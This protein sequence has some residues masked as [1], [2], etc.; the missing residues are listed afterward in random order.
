MSRRSNIFIGGGGGG[1]KVWSPDVEPTADATYV[2]AESYQ[3]GGANPFTQWNPNSVPDPYSTVPYGL[4]LT[5]P[6]SQN[7]SFGYIRALLATA[8][9]QAF[10]ITMPISCE[11][12]PSGLPS[13]VTA[14]VIL[15]RGLIANPATAPHL[16]IGQ[17]YRA[18]N[19][20]AWIANHL[21]INSFNVGLKDFVF[22]ATSPSPAG[23]AE[24]LYAGPANI[25]RISVN[26]AHTEYC[27]AISTNG[28][29]WF[30]IASKR[31]LTTEVPNSGAGAINSF[32]I[33]TFND[34]PLARSLYVPWVRYRQSATETDVYRNYAPEGGLL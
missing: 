17:F 32:G 2:A 33:Q 34:S 3:R 10:S 9:N 22:V 25:F 8:N 11:N 26:K 27:V 28:Q 12:A 30:E 31:N 1:G 21:N 5:S 19:S 13:T 18:G 7:Q 14:T 29:Q 6:A 15:G 24:Y 23:I 16:N 4:K 20:L